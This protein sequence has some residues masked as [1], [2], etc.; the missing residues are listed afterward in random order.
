MSRILFAKNVH[1]CFSTITK[2]ITKTSCEM[3]LDHMQ[4]T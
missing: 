2:T 4:E 1:R 3:L